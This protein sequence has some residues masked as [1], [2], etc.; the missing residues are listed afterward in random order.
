MLEGT[1]SK[2]VLARKAADIETRIEDARRELKAIKAQPVA[3]GIEDDEAYVTHCLEANAQAQA[4]LTR[5][6]I[7]RIVLTDNNIAVEWS[8]FATSL[9]EQGEGCPNPYFGKP[10]V[11]R[12]KGRHPGGQG[13]VSSLYTVSDFDSEAPGIA[14][15]EP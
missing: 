8:D 5:L 12:G 1:L 14:L 6:L 11:K 9:A 13:Q 3:S 4:E 15:R 2:D 7:N 10:V